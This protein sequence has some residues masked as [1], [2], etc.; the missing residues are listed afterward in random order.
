MGLCINMSKLASKGKTL[1]KDHNSGDNISCLASVLAFISQMV[2]G[3]P[4]NPLLTQLR[5]PTLLHCVDGDLTHAYR[6]LR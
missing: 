4:V 2:T 3:Q 1:R 5:D 6:A